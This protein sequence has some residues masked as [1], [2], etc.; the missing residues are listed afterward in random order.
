MNTKEALNNIDYLLKQID[1]TSEIIPYDNFDKFIQLLEFIK[2]SKL[3]SE[4][5]IIAKRLTIS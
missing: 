5:Q 1:H 2:G 4:E 3:K